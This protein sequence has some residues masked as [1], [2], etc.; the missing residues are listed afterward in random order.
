M[1]AWRCQHPTVAPRGEEDLFQLPQELWVACAADQ[2]QVVSSNN[3]TLNIHGTTMRLTI[4][5]LHASE[6]MHGANPVAEIQGADLSDPLV[7]FWHRHREG[8]WNKLTI[9]TLSW[10]SFITTRHSYLNR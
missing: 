8:A 1:S 2:M 10:L 9:A 6:S 3:Q 4:D 7:V 5:Q